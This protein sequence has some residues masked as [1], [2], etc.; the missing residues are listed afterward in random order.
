[1]FWFVAIP[2][3]RYQWIEEVDAVEVEW[4]Y[5]GSCEFGT[6]GQQWYDVLV[7]LMMMRV[8]RVENPER[9]K[10][11]RCMAWYAVVGFVLLVWFVG[12]TLLLLSVD[13]SVSSASAVSGAHGTGHIC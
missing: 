5:D 13:A 9:R 10:R 8:M 6:D 7:M 2:I 3:S 12:T 11:K 4:C 1:V